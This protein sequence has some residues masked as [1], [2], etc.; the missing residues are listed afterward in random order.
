MNKVT[1]VLPARNCRKDLHRCLTALCR[2]YH[3]PDIIVVDDDS[4]D[5]TRH[6]IRKHWPFVTYL[7]LSAHKED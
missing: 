3:V 1:A 6:M 7:Q 2:G 5:R 4:N